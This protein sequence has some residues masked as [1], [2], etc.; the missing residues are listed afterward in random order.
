M[1]RLIWAYEIQIWVCFKASQIKTIQVFQSITF[2]SRKNGKKKIIF[3]FFITSALWY[4]FNNSLHNDLNIETINTVV[5]VFNKKFHPKLATQ[6]NP[7]IAL[8]A[9]PN[10]QK[11]SLVG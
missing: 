2:H 7:L 8:K 10:C 6:T 1:L 3:F 9:E 4:V 5:R 11:I